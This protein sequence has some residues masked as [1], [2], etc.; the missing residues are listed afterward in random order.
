[1]LGMAG[2]V[3]AGPIISATSAVINSGGPGFG[4]ITDTHD[5]SGLEVGYTSGVDDFDTYISGD[6]LHSLIFARNEWSS[7]RGLTSASVTYDLGSL[8]TIDAVALWNEDLAGI[9]LL[10]L[11]GSEDGVDFF[12]LALGLSPI[13]NNSF[14]SYGAE[15]FSFAA[16]D[17]QFVRFDMSECPQSQIGFIGCAIGEV[18]FRSADTAAS[19]TPV[20]EPG[21]LAM[22]GM[23][24]LGVSF[25]MR[26]RRRTA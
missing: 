21:T 25:V 7:N 2:T 6:P 10:D 17:L 13:D 22:L 18:A 4:S 23:G 1:M 15:V 12:A 3:S 26:R 16:A 5:Q 14:G 20:P 19:P 11:F 9:T 24:M 8:N